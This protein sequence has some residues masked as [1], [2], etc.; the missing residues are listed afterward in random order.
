MEKVVTFPV[1]A[2]PS[3]RWWR[4]RSLRLRLAAW[5]SLI[6]CALLLALLPLVYVQIDRRLNADLDRQIEI[7]WILIEAHLENDGSGGVRWRAN[8]PS[9][10]SSGG[11]AESWFDVWS[12]G[13]RLMEHWPTSGESVPLPPDASR[14]GFHNLAFGDFRVVRTL[15]KPAQIADREV[16]LR[17]FHDK[18]GIRETLH[19]IL[20]GLA[21]GMPVAVFLAAVGGYLM[22]GRAL[23][24]VA[25]M[26]EQARQITS[27]SLG[28]RLSNPNPHDEIGELATVFN[29]T[30]ARLE[31]SFEALKR[32]TADASHELR[33]PLTALHS[34]GEIALRG[35]S[36]PAA[37]RETIGSMLE[38]AQKLHA[39][40]DTLLLLARVESG[41]FPGKMTQVR[42]DQ[43]ATEVCESIEVL[44]SEKQQRIGLAAEGAI[45]V[46][47]EAILLRQAIMN[48]VHNAIRYSPAGSLIQVACRDEHGKATL[49]VTDQGPGIS[50]EHHERVF[51]RFYRIDQARSRAEGGTGLGL[52]LAKLSIEAFGGTIELA[53][54]PG[55]GSTFQIRLPLLRT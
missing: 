21:L 44:A 41:R 35:E 19:R 22:A 2:S 46:E 33:T 51:D 7:D 18:A 16:V 27:E 48:L 28:R 54:T 39:L 5:F 49:A 13:L 42:L 11:Y 45:W 37:L 20:A 9:T 55:R 43:L 31:T 32:F 17:L 1:P 40:T 34:V 6:A 50:K 24:P 47:A 25:E 36:D 3:R 52:A 15:Q 4:R 23:R 10:L 30:L 12:G 26:A 29:G 8:S 14:T 38:E 53:S